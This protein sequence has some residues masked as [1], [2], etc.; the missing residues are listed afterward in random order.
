MVR[1]VGENVGVAGLDLHKC[2]R[3]YGQLLLDEG[4]DIETVSV[5]YG[6]LPTST[7][8]TSYCRKKQQKALRAAREIWARRPATDAVT[9][10]GA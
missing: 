9:A 1:R 2:W 3:T 4:A 8:E 5:L 10:A 6:H 7:T